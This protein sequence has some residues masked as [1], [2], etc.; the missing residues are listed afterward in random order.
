MLILNKA[1]ANPNSLDIMSDTSASFSYLDHQSFPVEVFNEQDS[2][3]IDVSKIKFICG[4]IISD[5]GFR[6]GRLG[7]VLGDNV[8]THALNRKY[9]GH[10]YV[11]DVISFKIECFDTHL[12]AEMVVSAEVAKERC[13]EFGWDDESELMLYVIH[14]TLHQVGYDDHTEADAKRM[15]QKEAMYLRQLGI[16]NPDEEED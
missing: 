12:E 16:F 9:L 14:G 5:A 4:R 8:I 11:T 3:C 7:I 2:I 13:E 1:F 10:D 6:T 15:H